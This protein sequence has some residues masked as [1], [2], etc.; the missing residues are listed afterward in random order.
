MKGE[1][2]MNCLGRLPIIMRGSC[3]RTHLVSCPLHPLTGCSIE[4]LSSVHSADD[5]V[6]VSSAASLEN[7]AP[8]ITPNGR[9][10]QPAAGDITPYVT[11]TLPVVTTLGGVTVRSE[12]I[13]SF[14]VQYT[15]DSQ[16]WQPVTEHGTPRVSKTWIIRH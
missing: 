2:K 12:F 3:S 11:I 6:I 7:D 4:L 8:Q 16:N 14:T 15:T 1:K 9:G 5:L 10:W 13:E